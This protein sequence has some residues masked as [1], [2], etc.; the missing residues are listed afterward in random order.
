MTAQRSAGVNV[1][2]PEP[3]ESVADALA[4]YRARPDVLYA[5]PNGVVHLLDLSDPADTYYTDQWALP[6]ISAVGGWSVF[7]GTFGAPAGAPIGIVD[8][9]VDASH[10]DLVA[11]VAASGATCLGSG[12]ASGTPID[13][14]GHGTHVSGI[15]GAAKPIWSLAMARSTCT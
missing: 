2:D 14:W 7:P 13:P 3:G 1:I 11:K 10:P 9:G 4:R 12:C 5:E 8:T 6:A 15:A